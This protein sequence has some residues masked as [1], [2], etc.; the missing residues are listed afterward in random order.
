MA[1]YRGMKRQI[2][3]KEFQAR[4]AEILEQNPDYSPVIMVTET[5]ASTEIYKN[6]WGKAWGKNLERFGYLSHG[7][8]PI[9]RGEKAVLNNGIVDLRIQ[10]GN[11]TARI[12]GDSYTLFE[13]TATIKPL[14]EDKIDEAV[15]IA[16]GK[17]QNIDALVA[18]NFPEDL[19]ELLLPRPDDV[20]RQ[21]NCPDFS[22]NYICS[23]TSAI[24]Y[25]IGVRIDRDPL[26][27]FEIRGIDV[28]K[29]IWRVVSGRVEKM[30]ENADKDSDRILK[31]ID[32]V[33][34]FGVD[35]AD[36]KTFEAPIL[37]ECPFCGHNDYEWVEADGQHGAYCKNCGA[38]LPLEDTMEDYARI[39][40]HWKQ[41]EIK[42]T[43]SSYRA[44]P[45]C[46]AAS[47]ERHNEYNWFWHKCTECGCESG[48]AETRSEAI[49]SWNMRHIPANKASLSLD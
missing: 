35:E 32:L 29:F 2:S 47:I 19:L 30:L 6:W 14:P 39:W 18:G 25:G 9:K 26:L 3:A 40:N 16:T 38:G 48:G 20:D 13:V 21:C 24:L 17:I 12:I 36:T 28:D 31:D 8:N 10:A 4:S 5:A 7:E 23:H 44:C 37:E 34:K 46:G 42:P 41:T 49:Q 11:I 15:S 43:N 22:Y 33:A 45:I 27:L 1:Y